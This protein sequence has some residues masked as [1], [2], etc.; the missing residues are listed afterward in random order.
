M[1]YV[2]YHDNC[3]DGFASALV[4]W[5]K[6]RDAATYIAC[7]YGQPFPE[8]KD[9]EHIYIVDFSFPRQVM[10]GLADHYAS[11]VTV[12]DHHKTAREALEGLND[13]EA[14]MNI[15]FNM[16]HSGAVLTWRHFFPHEDEPLFFQY[17]EDRDLWHWSLPDS[18][19]FSAGLASFPFEFKI[20]EMIV[21]DGIP[22]I[23][24]LIS[25]GRAIQ[26]Y[27]DNL[28]NITCRAAKLEPFDD[29]VVPVVNSSCLFSEVGERLLELFPE[30]PFAVAWFVND[31]HM[32]QYSMR[33]RP[34][35]DVSAVAKK[36]GGGG[37]AGAAGTQAEWHEQHLLPINEP[38]E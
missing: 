11:T 23:Q 14:G 33:S 7:K 9:A 13:P 8:L 34:G 37:H 29:Y 38:T 4:A 27:K 36:L 6:F 3:Y 18:R 22:G 19:E 12:L 2:L 15:Y 16:D 28:I 5:M 30:A 20:W 26:R 24:V 35:F 1:I 21:N 31:A 10:E 32:V 17:I 25:D